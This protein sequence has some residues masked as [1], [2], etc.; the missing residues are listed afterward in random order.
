M[1]EPTCGDPPGQKEGTII[2]RSHQAA[3]RSPRSIGL[4]PSLRPPIPV[5]Q[6]SW[7]RIGLTGD[8]VTLA[9][10]GSRLARKSKLPIAR[11]GMKT[12]GDRILTAQLT[13]LFSFYGAYGLARISHSGNGEL[14]S[15]ERG[16]GL[17]RA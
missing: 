2:D 1:D 5:A 7:K 14:L 11:Y 6:L 4:S 3:L 8:Y 13:T 12:R 9:R 10:F 15:L 17:A 16:D